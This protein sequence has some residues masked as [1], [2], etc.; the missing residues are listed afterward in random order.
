MT[1]K[2]KRASLLCYCKFCASYRSHLWIQTG[3]TVWNPPNWG[4]FILTFVTLGFDLWPWPFAWT[5]LLSMVISWWH[6][7][8][9]VTDAPL[10]GKKEVS[11]KLLGRSRKLAPNTLTK[12]RL[13]PCSKVIGFMSAMSKGGI[14]IQYIDLQFWELYY[15]MFRREQ[16]SLLKWTDRLRYKSK[17]R[18]Y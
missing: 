14:K 17:A 9:G 16:W 18:I 3:I 4:N 10:D 6:C 15:E 5:S 7:A 1:W 8:K 11:S 2:N 12:P 13:H